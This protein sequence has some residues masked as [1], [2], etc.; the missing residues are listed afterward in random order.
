MTKT[1]N[2]YLL[3]IFLLTCFQVQVSFAQNNP[4]CFLSLD[5]GYPI[6]N[7]PR[8]DNP[9]G[10]I[11]V[12]ASG[13]GTVTYQLNSNPPR[14]SGLFENLSTGSYTITMRD[15]NDC[16]IQLTVNLEGE[17]NIEVE[18]I[19]STP[20]DCTVNNGTITVNATGL[21]LQ[22]SINGSAFQNGNSFTGLSGGIYTVRIRDVNDCIET[23]QVTVIQGTIELIDVD[24]T[25]TNCIDNDGRIVATAN[26]DNLEYRLDGFTGWQSS[27]VFNNLP[28]GTYF[29][30]IRDAE[31]CTIRRRYRIRSE[32]DYEIEIVNP[33]CGE[34]NGQIIIHV[35]EPGD[36]EYSIDGGG[37][38]QDS[39]VFS[40][41]APGTYDVV[42]Q[43][44]GTTCRFTTEV[45]V[46]VD[47]EITID[48]IQ[49]IPSICNTSSGE[50]HVQATG[51][52]LSYELTSDTFSETNST[53]DFV[54]LDPGNY[55]L[56]IIN[57]EGCELSRSLRIVEINDIRVTGTSVTPSSCTEAEGSITITA[58]SR[59]NETLTYSLDGGSFSTN[60]HF[61][62]LV[63]GGYVVTIMSTSGCTLDVPVTVPPLNPIII[64]EIPT[65][66]P[67]SV[68]TNDGEIMVIAQ[69]NNL[70]FSIDNVNWQTSN[71][72]SNLFEGVY[73]IYIRSSDGCTT[74]T[75][76]IT[77]PAAFYIEDII[78]NNVFC[79]VPNGRA[80]IYAI[81]IRLE[82]SV[83]GS[84]FQE[85]PEFE[86]LAVGSHTA[87]VRDFYDCVT[88]ADF[89]VT[90]QGEVNFVD[91][92]IF[93]PECSN[94]NAT[95]R[96]FAESETPGIEYWTQGV[97]PSSNSE[98][99]GFGLGVHRFFARDE[100]GC[101]DTIDITVIE[102]SEVT[103][104]V[105]IEDYICFFQDGQITVNSEGG[106][107]PFTY[108]LDSI[109]FQRSNILTGLREGI[110]TVYVL[111]RAGC[112]SQIEA[113]VGYQ[114]EAM[115][116]NAITPDGNGINDRLSLLHE[117]YLDVQEFRIFN[118]WGEVVYE[119][120]DFNTEQYQEFWDGIDLSPTRGDQNVFLYEVIYT[121]I[122][123]SSKTL[124]GVVHLLR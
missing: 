101:R 13:F 81:G 115:V 37:T 95:I 24:V 99:S 45:I 16:E 36:F 14:L 33:L 46:D 107:A 2:C 75:G 34:N 89:E 120:F 84:P 53:G 30:E 69:G 72:F 93:Y 110:Y 29:L 10:S 11:E 76:E 109:N 102:T 21:G 86:N 68:C 66:V 87:T 64:E 4:D 25:H 70:E 104:T 6:I 121:D 1:T 12:V 119:R 103:H 28:P 122:D 74:E 111:D 55:T 65:T 60:G 98:F 77:L 80:N 32:L 5:S 61:E 19:I 57:N 47:P 63:A 52:G 105:E 90:T 7:S 59:R 113:E 48:N 71:V 42:V 114:C 116:P 27:P 20:S 22:Y 40:N 49:R 23:R 15:D 56:T 73:I 124:K 58:N 88:S 97:Q 100:F 44:A 50:I 31:G 9:D 85:S 118:S 94:E 38:F 82:Y 41:V 18:S 51:V 78:V 123:D 67:S 79:G 3:L 26:G 108:S 17:E 54:G 92:D 62:P 43:F 96:L 91:F 8:C 106:L 112:P 35:D 83:D 117:R 39:N